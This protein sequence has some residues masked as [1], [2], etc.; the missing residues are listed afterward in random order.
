M[1]TAPVFGDLISCP[2]KCVAEVGHPKDYRSGSPATG[3]SR[4]AYD[5][6]TT[7]T[8]GKIMVRTILMVI[9]AIVVILFILRALG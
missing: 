9:G 8:K 2:V 7:R 1:E 4:Q 6:P 5:E 3:L